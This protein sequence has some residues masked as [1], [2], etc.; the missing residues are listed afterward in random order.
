MTVIDSDR[1][2]RAVVCGSCRQEFGCGAATGECWCADVRVPKTVLAELSEEFSDCLCP[3]CLRMVVLSR[4]DAERRENV[5]GTLLK[6][7]D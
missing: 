6:N 3:N 4:N 7:G 1:E 5:D 2:A